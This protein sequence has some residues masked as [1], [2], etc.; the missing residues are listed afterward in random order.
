MQ[1]CTWAAILAL[2]R[3]NIRVKPTLAEV[4]NGVK[5]LCACVSV[6]ATPQDFCVFPCSFSVLPLS[7]IVNFRIYK[8]RVCVFVE[9]IFVYF[10]TPF[11]SLNQG[12]ELKAYFIA[13]I[14]CILSRRQILTLSLRFRGPFVKLTEVAMQHI[15]CIFLLICTSDGI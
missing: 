3:P 7:V 12:S 5:W 11:R 10:S 13:L 15:V 9:I 4:G 2:L 8:N 1:P 14:V 6:V